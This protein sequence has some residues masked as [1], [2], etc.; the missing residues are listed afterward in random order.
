MAVGLIT[1][2][3]L[4]RVPHGV[5]QVE[6]GPPAGVPLV[7]RDDLELGASAGEDHVAERGWGELLQRPDSLPQ[8]SAGDQGRLQH[9]GE[10]ARQLLAGQRGEGPRVG[11]DG[12]RQVVGADV[13]LGLRQVHPGLA[14]IGGVNLRDER[15]GDLYDRDPPLVGG[16]A[17][18]R[19][20]THDPTP[21]RHQVVGSRHPQPRKLAKDPLGL[22]QALGPLAR[23]DLD[24]AGEW[25]HRLRVE[26]G[27]GVIRDT[28]APEAPAID[29]E[30]TQ[31]P[32]A[33]VDGV[34]T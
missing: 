11:E 15:G 1:G 23:L 4:D 16:G 25:P 22:G 31:D 8:P 29:R 12:P 20:V 21:E 27:D 3:R 34:L 5:P 33:H 24:Q 9:L 10:P 2:G 18:A 28:E 32:L 19:E 14:P 26:R 30:R 6:H 7:G 13:V 17:E